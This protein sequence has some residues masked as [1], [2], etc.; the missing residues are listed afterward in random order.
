MPKMVISGN[1]A[2]SYAARLAQVQVVSAYPITPETSIVERLA[3]FVTSGE[4]KA[5]FIKVESEHSALQVCVSASSLG[6]RVYTAT[7][8]QGLLL[9]HELVHWASGMRNPIVM[10]VVNRA[11]APPWNIG[12][13]HTDTI[14]QRDTGWIQF[15]A[16]SNQEVLDTV[17]QAYRL[18]EDPAV[19]LPVM[20]N[21]DAFYLSHTYEPVD[22]PDPEAVDR[23]L[24]PRDPR[25]VLIPGRAIRVGSFTGPDHYAAFR[26]ELALA[27]ANVFP[28]LRHL[29]EEYE[30]IFGRSYGG[31]VDRYR[32]D[33]ADAVL[34][35]VGTASTTARRVVDELRSEGKRVGLAKLRLFRPFPVD[36][37]RALAHS[38]GRIGVVDRAYTFGRAGPVA[39]EVQAAL[40]GARDRPSVSSY[41]AGIGG[42][43]ITPNAVRRI[44]RS[45]LEDPPTETVWT[46][47]EPDTEVTAHG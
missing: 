29:E 9:M 1:E 27:T 43:D 6:A 46:D 32:T 30:R 15:Y 23:F 28:T 19:R 8:S 24:P 13:D 17:L 38:V 31:P 44:F 4:L 25:A 40:Y 16:E 47:L 41:L 2:Q 5:Q 42:R 3:D 12:S 35:T 26:H 45:L 33:G 36:D 34:V 20:V 14:S 37:V 11:V 21:E 22:I 10:G 39:E 7:S 18:A